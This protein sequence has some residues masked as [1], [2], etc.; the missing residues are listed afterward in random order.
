MLAKTGTAMGTTSGVTRATGVTVAT[1]ATVMEATAAGGVG[2][3]GAAS[4]EVVVGLEQLR[5]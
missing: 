2:A 1:G 3:I 4:P 5:G